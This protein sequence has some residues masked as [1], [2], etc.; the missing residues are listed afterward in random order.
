M[1]QWCR[2]WPQQLQ[3]GIPRGVHW[4]KAQSPPLCPT[5][6]PTL[7]VMGAGDRQLLQVGPINIW[8][9]FSG[10]IWE[11]P[12]HAH[13]GMAARAAGQEPGCP[14]PFPLWRRPKKARAQPGELGDTETSQEH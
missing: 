3:Y 14:S 2:E 8:D 6:T 1:S 7:G 9:E 11:S 10:K 12:S 13:A 5:T 4:E